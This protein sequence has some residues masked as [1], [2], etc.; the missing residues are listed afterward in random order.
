[1]VHLPSIGAA[2]FEDSATKKDAINQLD[3]VIMIQLA[4]KSESERAVASIL[5]NSSAIAALQSLRAVSSN[6][7]ETQGRISSAVRVGTALGNT[8]YWSI[9]GL[10]LESDPL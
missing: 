5:T 10:L 8:A 6:L 1:M 4:L 3:G 9:S 7:G 2:S